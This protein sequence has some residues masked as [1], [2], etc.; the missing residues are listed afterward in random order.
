[1]LAR[2]QPELLSTSVEAWHEVDVVGFLWA[3]LTLFDDAA[4]AVCQS[5]RK[6]P[7]AR[8]L[9]DGEQPADPAAV[10]RT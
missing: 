4:D 8:R 1:V 2:G 5:A 6:R 9:T 10:Q 3:Y 7:F